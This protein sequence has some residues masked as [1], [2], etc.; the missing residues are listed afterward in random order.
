MSKISTKQNQSK[1]TNEKAIATVACVVPHL[2]QIFR[3]YYRIIVCCRLSCCLLM[4]ISRRCERPG[5]LCFG[6]QGPPGPTALTL[7]SSHR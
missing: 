5:L 3:Y 2:I 6:R 1:K 7:H 4:T